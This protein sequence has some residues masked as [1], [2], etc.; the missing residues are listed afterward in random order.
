MASSSPRRRRFAAQNRTRRPSVWVLRPWC[1][2]RLTSAFA[3]FSAQNRTPKTC[4]GG[5]RSHPQNA[6]WPDGSGGRLRMDSVSCRTGRRPLHPSGKT[7]PSSR[8]MRC[9]PSFLPSLRRLPGR[10]AA[11]P[12]STLGV[13][14]KT[15]GA[16]S[17][18]RAG[19]RFSPE[20]LYR[21]RVPTRVIVWSRLHFDADD[22][23]RRADRGSQQ[24]PA[25]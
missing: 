6:E 5:V 20:W 15:L 4:P 9:W 13:F 19:N 22:A 14:S 1:A 17:Y 21:K 8:R 23:H 25:F 18:R 24:R 7:L 3:A 16:V 12:L 10:C 2:T 11:K